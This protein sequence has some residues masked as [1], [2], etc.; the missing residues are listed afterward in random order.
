MLIVFR[1]DKVL[2]VGIK[3][4]NFM[5]HVAYDDKIASIGVLVSHKSVEGEVVTGAIQS[6]LSI[7]C[8]QPFSWYIV[9]T[10]D[11]CTVT[12]F[13]VNKEDSKLA[14]KSFVVFEESLSAPFSTCS[15][16]TISHL[17]SVTL[18]LNISWM[19]TM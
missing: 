12:H 18:R 9:P 11:F 1:H 14:V 16:S 4:Q 2:H 6:S 5:Q 13:K 3:A 10:S 15:A 7:L 8:R 17:Y 19:D